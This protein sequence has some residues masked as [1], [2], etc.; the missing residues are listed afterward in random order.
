MLVGVRMTILTLVMCFTWV[1]TAQTSYYRTFA[2][3]DSNG[4]LRSRIT[5]FDSLEVMQLRDGKIIYQLWQGKR[6]LHQRTLSTG[7]IA[8]LELL[9]RLDSN[10]YLHEMYDILSDTGQVVSI[11]D[12][13]SV[14]TFLSF[15]HFPCGEWL[16]QG[17]QDTVKPGVYD[18]KYLLSM[19]NKKPKLIGSIKINT[20]EWKKTPVTPPAPTLK[21]GNLTVELTL[22]ATSCKGYYLGF[23]AQRRKKGTEKW[24][25]ISDIINVNPYYEAKYGDGRYLH[26]MQDT[27]P[28]NHVPYE[29]RIIG[30]DYFGEYGPPGPVVEC[31]GA[32]PYTGYVVPLL[33][34]MEN[35]SVAILNW[36]IKEE[37]LPEVKSIDLL[38]SKDSLDGNYTLYKESIDL[39]RRTLRIDVPNPY[40]TF[41]YRINTIY[42]QEALSSPFYVQRWDTKPPTAPVDLKGT[43]DSTGIVRLHWTANK[44]KDLW[45][46]R[47]FFANNKTDEFSLCSADIS[48]NTKFNDTIRLDNL[49]PEIYYKIVALDLRG[50]ISPFSDIL[51]I[52]K[53]DTIPPAPAFIKVIRQYKN[54]PVLLIRAVG[55]GSPDLHSQALYRRDTTETAFSLISPLGLMP[56][57]SV[58]IDS[59]ADYGHFYEYKIL[60]TDRSGNT[61]WSPVRE[62][63][64]MFIGL[65]PVLSHIQAEQDT[66]KKTTLLQWTPPTDKNCSLELYRSN[67]SGLFSQYRTIPADTG[68]W[69]EKYTELSYKPSYQAKVIYPDGTNSR[70]MSVPENYSPNERDK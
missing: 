28:E 36:E 33:P 70:L 5:S 24:D 30:M 10:Y 22:N 16:G 13:Y 69:E 59:T 17:T 38:Y 32:K 51:T 47:I 56:T 49:S 68:E 14:L 8:G 25:F 66:V 62:Y 64:V 54:T 26:K 27:L 34:E 45:G 7:S 58:L 44:E 63:E 57:D 53:P 2:K 50:N 67:E 48:S 6:M 40:G 12:A 55:G 65:R 19:H 52:T 20:A 11:D 18:V 39:S 3:V 43:I 31:S 29:Y 46:Y 1:L 37:Y 35:D 15:F 41:R 9:T 42:G 4:I 23:N 21:C 61:R 60:A